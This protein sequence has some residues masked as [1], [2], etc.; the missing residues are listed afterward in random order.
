LSC[1]A[2]ARVEWQWYLGICQQRSGH[3]ELARATFL[4][5]KAEAAATLAAKPENSYVETAWRT[6][7]GLALAGLG[8]GDAAAEQGRK[9]VEMVPVSVDALEGPNWE[10]YLARIYATNDDAA[11][12][13]P[14]L[15]RVLRNPVNV[16]SRENL[17]IEPF[18]DPIRNDPGFQALLKD[19]A[20][21]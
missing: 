13:L 2:P 7:L 11:N 16:T 3:P 18:W 6:G 21:P 14:L 15:R 10:L 12:A 20:K 8:E 1:Y 19:N 9:V 4:Q 17:R 5:L